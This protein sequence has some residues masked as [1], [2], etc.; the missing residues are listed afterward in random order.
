MPIHDWNRVDAGIFHAFHTTWIAHLQTALNGGVLPRNC[1][2]LAE[3]AAGAIGPD[4]LTLH[5]AADPDPDVPLSSND[6][7]GGMAVAER[8]PKV[9][10]TLDIEKEY[11]LE[12]RRRLM[13]RHVTNHRILAIIEIVSPGNK[14]SERDFN[15][16]MRK[17]VDGIEQG[18]HFLV[19]DLFPPT[20]RDPQGIHAA[21]SAELRKPLRA[22]FADKPLT[23][24]SYCSAT[25]VRAFVDPVAVG[26]ALT[27][28]PLFLTRDTYV[29]TP[30]ESTY[31]EAYRGV[32]Q[33]WKRVLES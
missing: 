28:M 4:V 7:G 30:L 15:A 27:E 16:F 29:E 25:I 12:K 10:F 33:I 1:Y 31:L 18:V 5:A 26:D 9:K 3:Q 8:P 23:L 24:A 13:I 6:V 14:S 20:H 32:P 19:V 21:I 11:Y 2:A 22:P 17:V